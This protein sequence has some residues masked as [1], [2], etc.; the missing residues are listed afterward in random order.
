M[1]KIPCQR[2]PRFIGSPTSGT[3]SEVLSNCVVVK[4]ALEKEMVNGI[5]HLPKENGMFL[6]R[7]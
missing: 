5:L 4:Q 7:E 1:I 2:Q 6:C 3:F